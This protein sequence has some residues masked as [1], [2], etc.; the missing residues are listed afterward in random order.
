MARIVSDEVTEKSLGQ[1]SHHGFV[2]HLFLLR[3]GILGLNE[4][5]IK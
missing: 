1:Q 5:E 4:H 3:H 2:A